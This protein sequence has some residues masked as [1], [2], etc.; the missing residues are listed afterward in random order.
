LETKRLIL[1]DWALT[2]VADMFEYAQIP[3]VGI[4][5]GWMPHKNIEE[6]ETI[7]RR[8]MSDNDVWAICD[9]EAKKVIGSVGLHDRTD[10]SGKL[11]K[12][13]GYVLSPSFE[14]QGLMTE[15]CRAVIRYSFE[16]LEI[17]VLKV[18]HF[19]QNEKSR[20]VI[21][22]LLF[23][24]DEIIDIKTAL[25]IV[26]SAKMYHLNREEYQ[27]NRRFFNETVES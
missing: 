4:S 3:S 15:A 8:F 7:V 5:A 24:F 27:N 9:K 13:L 18:D 2:D 10:L 16:E 12:E 17:D 25:G 20:R 22:R 19:V 14:H 26:Q 11:S 23:T 6:S 1:R 21:E